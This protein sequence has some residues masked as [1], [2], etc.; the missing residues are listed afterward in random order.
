MTVNTTAMDTRTIMYQGMTIMTR[1]V[2]NA[3]PMVFANF[4]RYVQ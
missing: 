1:T 4:V 3:S 2:A